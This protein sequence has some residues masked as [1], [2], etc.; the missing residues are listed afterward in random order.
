MIWIHST[1]F[2]NSQHT[3][4]GKIQL[5][6]WIVNENVFFSSVCFVYR[7]SCIEYHISHIFFY[8]FAWIQLHKCVWKASDEVCYRSKNNRSNLI[9]DLFSRL[10][11]ASKRANRKL[12]RKQ[13]KQATKL[14]KV[15][16]FDSLT[17]NTDVYETI[18]GP[19]KPK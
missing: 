8:L 6:F 1:R 5:S 16:V 13:P 10:L 15:N 4:Q 18:T 3:S 12:K 19:I 11:L 17:S 9:R 7:V 14:Q 2:H